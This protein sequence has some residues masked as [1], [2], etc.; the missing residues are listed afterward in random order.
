MARNVE[1]HP[2]RRHPWLAPPLLVALCVAVLP[3]PV[4]GGEYDLNVQTIGQAFAVLRSDG[5]T[6]PH[7]RMTQILRLAGLDLTGDGSSFLSFQTALRFDT[8]FGALESDSPVVQTAHRQN[9]V[10][11][12][13]AFLTARLFHR[14]LVLKVGRQIESD[15]LGWVDFDG[16]RISY[17]IWE[18]LKVQLHAGL[19]VKEDQGLLDTSAYDLDG[20]ASTQVKGQNDYAEP[21]GVLGGGLSYGGHGASAEVVLREQLRDVYDG[22]ESM[23][24]GAAYRQQLTHW[25]TTEVTSVYDF[26]GSQFAGLE[27]EVTAHLDADLSAS[28]GAQRRRPVFD[29]DSIFNVF[30]LRA[31]DSLTLRTSWQLSPDLQ[32]QARAAMNW[33]EGGSEDDGDSGGG[34]QLSVRWRPGLGIWTRLSHRTDVDQGGRRHWTGLSANTPEYYRLAKFGLGVAH[35]DFARSTTAFA[36]T[37]FSVRADTDLRLGFWGLLNAAAEFRHSP[38]TDQDFRLFATL[39]LEFDL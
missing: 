7:R 17:R 2:Q 24:L 9:Q 28:V 18:G 20:T 37:A 4:E 16:A 36:G 14:R 5:E 8:D 3:G 22:V 13:Y 21:S 27:G 29:A 11:L 33:Y 31:R 26:Y 38:Y 10:D 1:K 35:L 34:G 30:D 15:S 32:L 19:E 12:L 23:R 6:T 25:V 39:N